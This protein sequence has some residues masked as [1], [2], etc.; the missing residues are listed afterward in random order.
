VQVGDGRRFD[1]QQHILRPMLMKA[2]ELARF[3][4]AHR[5]EIAVYEA[6]ITSLVRWSAQ[7]D[8]LLAD[9]SSIWIT[10]MTDCVGGIMGVCRTAVMGVGTSLEMQAAVTVMLDACLAPLR[11]DA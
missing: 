10:P 1:A 6:D 9:V 2:L 11:E 8:E 7:I 3:V 5:E 4:I